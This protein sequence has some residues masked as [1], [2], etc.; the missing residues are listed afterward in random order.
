M[1]PRMRGDVRYVRSPEGVYLEGLTGACT[2]KGAQAYEWLDRLAPHLTGD[3][4][5]GELVGQL[6]PDQRAMVEGLVRTLHEQGFVVDAVADVPHRLSDE[7][8]RVYAA[9][10][11]FIRY[12]VDSAEWRFQRLREARIALVGAGPVM[13][14]L[15]QAGLWSGWRA[16]RVLAPTG[17]LTALRKATEQARRDP[18]QEVRLADV[19]LAEVIDEVDVVLQVDGDLIAAGRTCAEA[20]AAVGQV[21]VDDS[22]AWCTPVGPWTVVDVESCWRRL[23]AQPRAEPATAITE[24]WLTGPVPEIIAARV[25]LSCFSHLTGLD[26]LPRPQ[27]A[28]SPP[29]L[30][31]IDLVTLDTRQHR[32]VAH[33]GSVGVVETSPATLLDELACGAPAH[34]PALLDRAAE[35]I[36]PRTG[37]LGRLAEEELAQIPLSMCRASVSDPYRL[38]PDSSP[39]PTVLG[40]GDNLITARLR[41]LLAG[42]ATYGTLCIDSGSDRP[43]TVWGLDLVSGRP[44]AVPVEAAYPVLGEPAVPYRAPV[45]AAAGCAWGEAVSAGMRAH[46]ARLI[47]GRAAAEEGEPP[48]LDPGEVGDDRAANL[49]RR[50]RTMHCPVGVREL[51][52]VLG[53]PAFALHAA[54]LAPVISCAG[55]EAEAL[56]DGLERVLLRLQADG[57]ACFEP[58]WSDGSDVPVLAEAVHRAGFRP[59]A[60]PIAR[61]PRARELLPY[62]VQVVLRGD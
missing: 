39:A 56:A 28:P 45:G 43:S 21:R 41:A 58:L 32:V 42:L 5:L 47:A 15:L 8:R 12:G 52:D 19:P 34:G 25:A 1:R 14:A 3:R 37:L 30:T 16:V 29:V 6:G 40:W 62:V 13:S 2:V 38:L 17:E 18:G 10:I 46:C 36:D 7:E 57:A 27:D 26:T 59:V 4:T 50:L 51:G 61:D 11:E 44:R 55:T 54:G 9:E 53:L 48:E 24:N 49:L 31:R 33:P 60:V 23:A 22:E 35:Y 20:G